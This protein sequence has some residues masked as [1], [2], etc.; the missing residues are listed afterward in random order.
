[1][2]KIQNIFKKIELLTRNEIQIKWRSE[3]E[4]KFMFGTER[5]DEFVDVPNGGPQDVSN[6]HHPAGHHQEVGPVLQE[7]EE[8]NYGQNPER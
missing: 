4:L 3:M 1:M 5:N 2:L 6:D 8:K 7:D